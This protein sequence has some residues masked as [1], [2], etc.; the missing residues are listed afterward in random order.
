MRK[1]LG[2]QEN[3]SLTVRSIFESLDP[4]NFGELPESKFETALHKIGVEMRAK[5]KRI[6]KDALDPR[7]LGFLRYRSLLRELQGVP[8]VDFFP[9]EVV[10]VA[11]AVVEARD[12]DPIQFK[13]LTDPTN[14]EMM[15]LPHLQ[16]AFKAMQNEQFQMGGEEVEA[17][18]KKLTRS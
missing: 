10:R 7:N 14:I 9:P 5:E 3:Q 6:V 12:L 11:K 2:R 18:F 4:Q 1:W 16:Q 13:R 15:D 17:M 8:M